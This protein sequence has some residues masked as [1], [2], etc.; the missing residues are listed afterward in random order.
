MSTTLRAGVTLS[1]AAAFTLMAAGISQAEPT[2]PEYAVI[3]R[4]SASF[5]ANHDSSSGLKRTLLR[6]DKAG[7]TRGAPPVY[8]G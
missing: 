7:H 5:C 3:V 2:V 1:S 8:N 4:D 6:G